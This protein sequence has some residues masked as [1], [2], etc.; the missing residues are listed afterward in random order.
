MELQWRPSRELEKR[1]NLGKHALQ[2]S[3]A[4][5]Q[6]RLEL[7]KH[8]MCERGARQARRRHI[9]NAH[10]SREGGVEP[11]LHLDHGYGA[12]PSRSAQEPKAKAWLEAWKLWR[13]GDDDGGRG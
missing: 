12:T 9:K 6:A 10:F 5:N 7:E 8:H 1:R 3:K 13:C 4:L 2:V 11:L